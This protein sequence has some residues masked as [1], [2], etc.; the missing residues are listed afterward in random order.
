MSLDS[1]WGHIATVRAGMLDATAGSRRVPMSHYADR[2]RNCLWFITAKDTHAAK[3]AADGPLSA[4][5]ILS[6]SGK[7]IFADIKGR[8]GLSDDRAI[9]LALWSPVADTWF[10][11]G[12]DDPNL[13]LLSFH[14]T[15]A[16]V[17]TTPTSGIVFMFDMMRAKL[18]GMPPEMGSHFTI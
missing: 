15:E 13:Q 5:Y 9:L 10:D 14:I 11:G 12:I 18:T 16:E 2:D 17:W 7:G 8:L 1:F 6:D 3:A 4:A